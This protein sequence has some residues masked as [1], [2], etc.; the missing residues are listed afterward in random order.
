MS[1]SP[2]TLGLQKGVFN[3]LSS[4]YNSVELLAQLVLWG[5][6]AF[7]GRDDVSVENLYRKF[8]Q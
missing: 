8:E 1:V 6:I 2:E 5:A 4:V 3:I 7:G